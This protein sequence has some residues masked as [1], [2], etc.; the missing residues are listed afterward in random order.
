MDVLLIFF[1]DNRDCK[2]RAEFTN[3]FIYSSKA[4]NDKVIEQIK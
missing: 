4:L 3:N 2:K 1:L